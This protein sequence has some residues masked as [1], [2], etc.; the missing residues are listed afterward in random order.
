MIIKLI[1][2]SFFIICSA[3]ADACEVYLPA[4]LV[5]LG[6]TTNFEQSI[7]HTGCSS[8]ALQ[9]ISTTMNSVEGKISAFQFSD[10]LK[11]KNHIV[12]VQP[13]LMQVQHLN[14]LVREQIMLPAGIQLR[15]SEAIN[16]ANFLVL[17]PGD[18]IEIQ[19]VGCLYGSQQPLNINVIGFDGTNK[20]VTVKADFKKMVKAYR[21]LGFHPAFSPI[22]ATSLKEEFVESIPHTD[23]ITNLET[24]HFFKLNKPVRS[25][26]LLRL[27][28]LN[29]LNLVKAGLK[30]EVII[31]NEHVKLKTQGISRSN[32]TLGEFVEVFHPQKNKKYQGKVIDIN[33]VLVEL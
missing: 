30:T 28:D 15:S 10:I 4:H 5:I 31:E 8:E 25:G 20:A 9:E 27:S 12:A 13:A 19:C 16:A 23:L 17:A 7:K 1:I 18:R 21:V 3:F 2:V 24:L 26:E 11:S 6:E 33:K 29:A 32:G 14:H 22:T